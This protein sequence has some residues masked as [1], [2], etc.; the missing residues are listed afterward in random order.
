MKSIDF[1][2]INKK[3]RCFMPFDESGN[4]LKSGMNRD[5]KN[6]FDY[7]DAMIYIPKGNISIGDRTSSGG[8][9]FI[10]KKSKNTFMA[11]CF[12][13]DTYNKTLKKL[14]GNKINIIDCYLLDQEGWIEFKSEDLDKVCRLVGAKKQ[15]KTPVGLTNKNENYPLFLRT[16]L[17]TNYETLK[18][19]DA[20]Y[21]RKGVD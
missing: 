19:L 8:R 12:Y 16:F 10:C 5:G 7:D 21:G 18:V 1:K 3:W 2:E 11:V 17:H 9:S 14:K 4:I 13:T 20:W 15:N 6:I